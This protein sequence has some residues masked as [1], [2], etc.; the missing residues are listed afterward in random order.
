MKHARLD[1]ILFI[2][3]FIPPHKA[4][5][6]DITPAP[7]RYRMVEI[8]VKDQA[9]FEISDIEY[10]RPDISYTIDTL[11]ELKKK[12]PGDELHLIVG[13]DSVSEISSWRE[14]EEI[15]K[16]AKVLAAGRP[17]AEAGKPPYPVEW[18]AMAPC[19]LSSSDLRA[20]MAQG[21][22]KNPADLPDGVEAFIR[23]KALYGGRLCK[24]S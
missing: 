13:A 18:I 17:G 16:L 11:R 5:R 8:A 19:A 1:K 2:P 6:R 15:F 7:Y 3:A 21:A 9:N 20:Q 14:P 23:N 10:C 4:G 24:S 22:L 12:Y